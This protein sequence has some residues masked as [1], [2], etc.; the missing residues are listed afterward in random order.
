MITLCISNIFRVFHFFQLYMRHRIGCYI[1]HTFMGAFGYADDILLLAPTRSALDRMLYFTN[2]FATQSDIT[3]NSTKCKYMKFS[4]A[5]EESNSVIFNGTT[6][7]SSKQEKHLGNLLDSSHSDRIITEAVHTL[8]F[9][10]NSLL[11]KFRHAP[12]NSVVKLCAF[13]SIGGSTSDVACSLNYI[14]YK[15]KLNKYHLWDFRTHCIKY[16]S[17]SN[18]LTAGIIRDFIKLKENNSIGVTDKRNI[19]FIIDY[20]CTN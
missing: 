3:F 19:S 18:S 5:K 20:L 7:K 4:W 9:R 15:Y 8:Y 13:L 1:E 17:H 12:T 16:N 6:I 14:C 2:G 11:F 10:F